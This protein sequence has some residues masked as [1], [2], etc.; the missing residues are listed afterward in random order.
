MNWTEVH[1][2]SGKH[3]QHRA[4]NKTKNKTNK[5]L[6]LLH[7]LNSGLPLIRRNI[8]KTGLNFFWLNK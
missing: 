4:E 2:S 3:L 6:P 7:E 1:H 8:Y 5:I